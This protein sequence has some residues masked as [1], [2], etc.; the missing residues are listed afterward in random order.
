MHV[1]VFGE[2][3]LVFLPVIT[4]P[5]LRTT[6]IPAKRTLAA[7]TVHSKLATNPQIAEIDSQMS[8]CDVSF[9]R[10]H[11]KATTKT[12]SSQARLSRG[13]IYER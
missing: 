6:A 2:P 3:V 10:N 13:M 5:P 4:I 11:D 7:A 1:M 8:Q 9:S 12:R